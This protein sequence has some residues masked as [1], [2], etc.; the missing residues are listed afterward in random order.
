MEANAAAATVIATA[1]EAAAKP[2]F[3]SFGFDTAGM[4]KSVAPG[5]DFYLY[6]NGT[7]A[8]NTQIPS[9]KSNYGAFSV[10]AGSSAS[11]ASVTSSMRQKDNPSSRIGM[12]YSSFLD[13]AAVEAKG[14]TPIEPWLS[15][16]RA[17][18]SRAGFAA[19]EGEAARNGITGLF[20]G[21][22]TQDDRNTDV[23]ITAL[24][25]AGLG[26]PDRDMY[27]LPDTNLVTAAG[28]LCRSPDQDADAGRRGQRGRPG[29]GDHGFRNRDREGVAGP[30][31]TS[32]TRPRLITR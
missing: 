20:G 17:L 9:D 5:D 12:A 19:L 31:K 25:Q 26:M 23:Y 2:Q 16:I 22:V 24:G 27:L 11:N 18:D 29:Q 13:E 8:K 21:F 7:W 15:Q 10:L 6:A 32:E 28:R 30:A 4:N 14:L 3:G 1:A